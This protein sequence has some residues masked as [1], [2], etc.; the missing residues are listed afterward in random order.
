MWS[1]GKDRLN[2]KSSI[3]LK[4]KKSVKKK[5]NEEEVEVIFSLKNTII[6]SL[7]LF[8]LIITLLKSC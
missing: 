5:D 2:N 6:I 7:S 4:I 8:I 1:N 3:F